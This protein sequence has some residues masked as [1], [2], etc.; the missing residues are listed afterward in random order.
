MKLLESSITQLAMR[1]KWDC[2]NISN[3]PIERGRPG[4]KCS[5]YFDLVA[6]VHAKASR[7]DPKTQIDNRSAPAA[8][9]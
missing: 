1:D 9:S 6:Y 4:N 7:I 8:L 3:A 5:Y 2:I